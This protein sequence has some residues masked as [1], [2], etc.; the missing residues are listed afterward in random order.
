MLEAFDNSKFDAAAGVY[1]QLELKSLDLILL[2][3]QEEEERIKQAILHYTGHNIFCTT[4]FNLSNSVIPAYTP[5]VSDTKDKTFA[6]TIATHPT[7]S[8]LSP[9]PTPPTTRHD[10]LEEIYIN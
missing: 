7:S 6:N 10:P 1:E 2:E 8:P 3:T 5:I 4:K 9:S